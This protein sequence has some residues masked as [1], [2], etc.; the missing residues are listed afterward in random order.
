M[1]RPTCWSGPN[2]RDRFA[3]APCRWRRRTVITAPSVGVV[4][5]HSIDIGARGRPERVRIVVETVEVNPPI[6][7]KRFRM[8]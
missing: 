1:R 6:D 4:I 5:P 3:A 8:P 2:P 7:D